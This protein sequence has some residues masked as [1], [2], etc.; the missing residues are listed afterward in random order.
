MVLP[1]PKNTHSLPDLLGPDLLF[2]FCGINPGL[3]SGQLQLHFAGPGNRFWKLLHAGGF[4]DHVLAPAEQSILPTLGVGITNLVE[5]P[6]K[7]ASELTNDE[8]QQ[9]PHRLEQIVM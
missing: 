4:T 5:R 2:L 1:P 6:T 3:Q 7:A 8:L 9:G